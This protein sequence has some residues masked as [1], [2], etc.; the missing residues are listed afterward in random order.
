MLFLLSLSAAIAGA[1]PATPATIDL[2]PQDRYALLAGLGA[3][4]D[5][6]YIV[7]GITDA[8]VECAASHVCATPDMVEDGRA[9]ASARQVGS[10]RQLLD[11]VTIDDQK[12]VAIVAFRTAKRIAPGR[13]RF[14]A[15]VFERDIGRWSN[16]VMEVGT[17]PNLVPVSLRS[18][19]RTY[20][21]Q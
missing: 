4:L 18:Q 2:N 13:I 16:K 19:L 6:R 17:S 5:G 14:V 21:D 11:S 20:R 3:R 7:S 8:D 1:A 12:P 10:Y 15:S 9:R